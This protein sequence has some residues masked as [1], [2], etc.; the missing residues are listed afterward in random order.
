MTQERAQTQFRDFDR[1]YGLTELLS[2]SVLEDLFS[3]LQKVHPL[4]LMV[5]MPDGT[6]YHAKGFLGEDDMARLRR[7]VSGGRVDSPKT[8]Q[9]AHGRIAIFPLLHQLETIGHLV[10]G[11]AQDG[12]RPSYPVIHLGFFL[13]KAFK[14]LIVHNYK[15]IMTAGLYGQ[16]V[17][18]SYEQ[19]KEKTFLLEKSEKK[20]QLLA[21]SLE[22]EVQRKTRKIKEAQS[23]LMQQE[24]LAAI[25][26]LA[27]GVA[28]EINNPLGFI[29][30]NLGTLKGYFADLHKLVETYHALESVAYAESKEIPKTEANLALQKVR[31]LKK[32]IDL[33][34]ILDDSIHVISESREGAGRIEKIVMNL[35]AFASIDHPEKTEIDINTSIDSTVN[36]LSHI[37][38]GKAEIIKRYGKIPP[39]CG[40][41]ARL[42]Q[43][44]MNLLRNAAQAIRGQGAITITTRDSEREKPHIEISIADTGIGIP[45]ENI[46]R[47]FEP[48]FTTR[49]VGEGM[50]L[51]LSTAYEII[52]SHGGHLRVESQAGHGSTF[53]MRIPSGRH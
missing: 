38:R 35:K 3:E 42:N 17:E 48:F 36:T 34:F 44:F 30:S 15:N 21:E 13:V 50:G 32:R 1:E 2:A 47:I 18:E 40:Y 52:K 49:E 6:P 19:L 29:K 37:L 14:Q 31:T 10:L 39:V 4:L 45:P 43:V 8:I 28:H 9:T 51:G 26:R 46:H 25:G 33:D 53:T 41:P 22:M 16:V 11:H 27:A 20:Y 5:L 7:V 23:Q 12:K 24:K